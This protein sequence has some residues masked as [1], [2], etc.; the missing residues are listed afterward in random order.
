MNARQRLADRRASELFG[1]EHRG[2]RFH[3]SFSRFPDGRPG[4]VFVTG[5]KAGT[6]VAA[7]INDAALLASVAMQHG[8][9]VSAL[10]QS[11]GR[12]GNGDPST[13]IGRAL[14]II[15]SLGDDR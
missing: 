1:F 11:L 12:D 7:N 3:A 8:A 6:D 2:M 15:V 10:A 14:Q 4:E 9:D 5:A 13:P